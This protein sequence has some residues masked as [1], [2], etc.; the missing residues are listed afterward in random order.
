MLHEMKRPRAWAMLCGLWLVAC[1]GDSREVLAPH[2]ESLGAVE[3]ELCAGLSVTT[4]TI[5]GIS[6]YQNEVAGS[7]SWAVSTGANGVRL[8]YSLGGVLQYTEERVGTSGTWYFSGWMA[9]GTKT[10]VVKAFPM[11]IDSAGN[12]S[13]CYSAPKSASRSVTQSC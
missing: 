13:T 2:E 12:R 10:F 7:G 1:G 11:V 4:L 6:S 5:A 9:C 3:S 8:E